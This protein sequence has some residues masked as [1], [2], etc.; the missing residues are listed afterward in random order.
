MTVTDAGDGLAVSDHGAV[1]LLT[2]DRPQAANAFDAAL[3]H[4]A[5]AA[6]DAAAADETVAVVVLTGR[7]RTFCAGTDLR[8]MAET[9]TRLQSSGPPSGPASAASGERSPGPSSSG[10]RSP[11]DV[12]LDALAGF[13]KPVVA[14]VNGAAVGLGFTML[15][16]CDLVLVADTARLLAPFAAMGVAPEAASS[17]LFP[18][19]MGRQ[20]AAE[21]LF[22]ARWLSADGAVA[23][24]LALASYPAD[25][26]LDAALAL[27]GSIAAHPVSSLV[28]V[29]RLL[30]D[31]EREGVARA[32]RAE[33]AAF[34]ELL[35]APHMQQAILGRLD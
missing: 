13:D 14:A 26:L 1:R 25:E 30:A 10:E 21:V 7:G 17:Y 5:G 28:A 20:R 22:T 16:H 6:L 8:E 4:A 32:R 29:K 3:Y 19:R 35:R 18:R 34:A 23:C 27:A 33:S 9:A 15:P 12:F 31:G 24:G 11:F 2:F